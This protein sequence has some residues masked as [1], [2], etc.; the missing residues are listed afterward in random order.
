MQSPRTVRSNTKKI[1]RVIE[2]PDGTKLT[3]LKWKDSWV[4]VAALDYDEP[5]EDWLMMH[6]NKVPKAKKVRRGT[7]GKGGKVPKKA[8]SL[9]NTMFPPPPPPPSEENV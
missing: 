1:L 3:K 7:R 9:M 2:T 8:P 4:D 6:A 5:L